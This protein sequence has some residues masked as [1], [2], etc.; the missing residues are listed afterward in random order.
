MH[1][2]IVEQDIQVRNQTCQQFITTYKPYKLS[3]LNNMVMH[4]IIIILYLHIPTM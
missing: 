2:K 4:N 3:E 1:V